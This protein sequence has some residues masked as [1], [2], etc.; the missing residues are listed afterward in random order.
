MDPGRDCPGQKNVIKAV[1]TQLLFDGAEEHLQFLTRHTLKHF[2][3]EWTAFRVFY[4]TELYMVRY[5]E[6][7]DMNHIWKELKQLGAETLVPDLPFHSGAEWMLP[8][9]RFSGPVLAARRKMR[10]SFCGYSIL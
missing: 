8:G 2:A 7:I 1:G 5:R 3:H 9:N 4:D 6:W 10:A